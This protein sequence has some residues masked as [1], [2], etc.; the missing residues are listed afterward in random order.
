VPTFPQRATI[1]QQ[2]IHNTTIPQ[3]FY[4]TAHFCVFRCAVFT[5]QRHHNDTT[6][7]RIKRCERCVVVVN[8]L[9]LCCGFFVERLAHQRAT[10]YIWHSPKPPLPS[11]H[12]WR[13]WSVHAFVV[14][15]SYD[16]WQLLTVILI[17]RILFYVKTHYIHASHNVV[18]LRFLPRPGNYLDSPSADRRLLS[19]ERYSKYL[20]EFT[21]VVV[22]G[23][24][25]S[26]AVFHLITFGSLSQTA[27]T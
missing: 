18:Y 6:T 8:P 1:Q 14:F 11:S 16:A 26:N 20:I 27:W 25:F 5:T 24:R 23:F 17:F 19:D 7:Q 13:W 15:L 12:W 10:V 2:W 9:L 3:Q 21:G 22:S 4:N